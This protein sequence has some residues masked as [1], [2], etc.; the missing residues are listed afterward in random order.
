ML[1]DGRHSQFG[2]HDGKLAGVLNL[3]PMFRRLTVR[4]IDTLEDVA[5]DVFDNPIDLGRATQFLSDQRNILIVAVEGS[6]VIG[7]VTAVVHQHV[8]SPPDLYIDNLGVT[9]SRQRRGVATQ[10]IALAIEV[11]RELHA[12]ACWVAVDADNSV[13]HDLYRRSGATGTPIMMFSYAPKP[14][15]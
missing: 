13:A 3:N 4:E 14:R 9:P 11:G 12:E 7:Q 5:A 2:Q 1:A 8:D 6:L 15:S 10:L